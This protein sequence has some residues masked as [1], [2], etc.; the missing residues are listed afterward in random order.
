MTK[1]RAAPPPE[2]FDKIS[3]AQALEAQAKAWFL[4]QMGQTSHRQLGISNDFLLALD[5][6]KRAEYCFDSTVS[7]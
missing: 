3:R 1:L 4:F 6:R 7:E 2:S 5:I